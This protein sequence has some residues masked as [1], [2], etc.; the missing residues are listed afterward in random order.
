MSVFLLFSLIAVTSDISKVLLFKLLSRGMSRL[1]S[2]P[3]LFK[4][5]IKNVIEFSVQFQVHQELQSSS[6]KATTDQYFSTLTISACLNAFVVVFVAKNKCKIV[7][8]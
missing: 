3:L 6:D 2:F 4:S 8:L 5:T 7:A 1:F